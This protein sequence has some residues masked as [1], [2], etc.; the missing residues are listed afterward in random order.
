[1]ENEQAYALAL[2]TRYD[3]A[4]PNDPVPTMYWHRAIPGFGR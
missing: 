3:A 2:E 4:F 1:M